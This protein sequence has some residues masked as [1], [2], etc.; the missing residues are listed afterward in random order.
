MNRIMAYLAQPEE[1]RPRGD[2]YVVAGFSGSFY[3]SAQVAGA[4]E[5]ALDRVWGGRWLVFRDLSGS[6]I[7]ILRRQVF[8]VFESTAE[9][10]AKDRAFFRSLD[11]ESEADR[12]P[13][14]D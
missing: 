9:Q 11:R 6:R 14:E 8:G 4:V 3:V 5:R 13:W 10:R 2:Y 12:R 7:R 1:R